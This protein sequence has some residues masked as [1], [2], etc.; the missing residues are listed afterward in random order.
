MAFVEAHGTG[1][2]LGDRAE[3]SA[4][5]RVLRPREGRE[6]CVVGSAKTCVG[7]SEAAVGAVGLIKAVLS[8][9]HGIVP[10]TPDF[11]GPCR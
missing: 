3:L 11:S 7:H 8:Q 5:N 1:T 2:V 4:L 10:G 6:R 9:E